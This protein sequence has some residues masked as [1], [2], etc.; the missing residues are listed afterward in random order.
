M[1]CQWLKWVA[2]ICCHPKQDLVY[3]PST[4]HHMF[5]WVLHVMLKNDPAA[6]GMGN[7]TSKMNWEKISQTRDGQEILY[8]HIFNA[9]KVVEKF[10]KLKN[11]TRL[12][13]FV[14]KNKAAYLGGVD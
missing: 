7:W 4:T 8:Q 3:I 6:E 11:P 1:G 12:Q 10:C 2:G 9:S 14:K 5:H 13:N